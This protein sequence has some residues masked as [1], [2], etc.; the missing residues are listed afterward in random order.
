[1]TNVKRSTKVKI[2]LGALCLTVAMLLLV[3]VTPIVANA[4]TVQKSYASYNTK[5]GEV[6]YYDILPEESVYGTNNQEE[7][8]EN[9]GYNPFE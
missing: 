8:G 5:T 4:A 9:S 6:S 7:G 2:T 1:M 3:I